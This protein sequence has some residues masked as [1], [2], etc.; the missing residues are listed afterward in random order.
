MP[1]SSPAQ[2]TRCCNWPAERSPRE[3]AYVRHVARSTPAVCVPPQPT[4]RGLY[5]RRER[6]QLDGR[7]HKFLK[8]PNGMTAVVKRT[9]APQPGDLVLVG[10]RVSGRAFQA[11]QSIPSQLLPATAAIDP[12]SRCRRN[13]RTADSATIRCQR[14]TFLSPFSAAAAKFE[15]K[16]PHGG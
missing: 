6:L 2:A 5:T 12:L 1:A 15:T 9:A 10:R 3:G 8:K 14:R 11:I 4:G 13:G 7:Q 16:M